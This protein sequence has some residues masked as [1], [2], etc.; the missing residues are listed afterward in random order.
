MSKVCKYTFGIIYLCLK[1]TLVLRIF[2]DKKMAIGP[3]VVKGDLVPKMLSVFIRVGAIT[4][5]PFIFIRSEL[6]NSDRILNHEKI[7]M[8][9]YAELWVLGFYFLY[10]WD[11]LRGAIKYRSTSKAYYQIRF[12][13]EAYDNDD[14]MEYLDNRSKFCWRKY[15]V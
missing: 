9:Q 11:F 3:Y 15:S 13:Q 2:G 5:W 12:E 7:H 4:L 8:A 1:R 6:A 10:V 14:N